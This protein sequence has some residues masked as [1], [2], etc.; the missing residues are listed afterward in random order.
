MIKTFNKPKR[1]FH[2]V[3]LSPCQFVAAMSALMLTA[4]G[5]LY[6][7]RYTGGLFFGSLIYCDTDPVLVQASVNRAL[8]LDYTQRMGY[9]VCAGIWFSVAY[10]FVCVEVV[11]LELQKGKFVVTSKELLINKIFLKFVVFP[12]ATLI[13][14]RVTSAR[15]VE[16][17]F[18]YVNTFVFPIKKWIVLFIGSIF[19]GSAISAIDLPTL[20]VSYF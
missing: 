6:F 11:W 7:Y 8:D 5:V 2:V 1:S 9:T 15:F 20:I 14:S 3:D 17:V 13:K 4:G 10:F 18:F 12:L 16:H 19:L